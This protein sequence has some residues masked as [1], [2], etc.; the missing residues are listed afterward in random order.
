[1]QRSETLGPKTETVAYLSEIE[2]FMGL[3]TVDHI[4]AFLCVYGL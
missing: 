4:P 1:M 2:I 3:E